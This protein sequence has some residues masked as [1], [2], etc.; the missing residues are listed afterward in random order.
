MEMAINTKLYLV[1]VWYYIKAEKLS[2]AS[3]THPEII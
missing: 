3:V 2:H 1:N